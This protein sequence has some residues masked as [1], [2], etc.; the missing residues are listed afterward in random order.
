MRHA[1]FVDLFFFLAG[2]VLTP[3]RASKLGK[4]PAVS[5]SRS[6][7]K[8]PP[9]HHLTGRGSLTRDERTATP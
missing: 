1:P 8:V 4:Q 3:F 6:E 7:R 5:D 2:F 9:A